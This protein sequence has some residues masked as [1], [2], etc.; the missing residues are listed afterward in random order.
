MNILK[1]LSRKF[2]TYIKTRNSQLL[3]YELSKKDY[4]ENDCGLTFCKI[5]QYFELVAFSD[6]QGHSLDMLLNQECRNR[7]E[8]GS[9]MIVALSK[10]VWVSYG[11]IA[12]EGEF[13]IAEID[14]LINI[15]ASSNNAVLFDF[16]T[17]EEYR[18]HGYYPELLK[19]ILSQPYYIVKSL[20]YCY[21]SNIS[22]VR[23][24][25]KAGG[26]LVARLNHYSDAAIFFK[27][28]GMSQDGSKLKWLGLLYN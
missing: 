25:E 16:A 3:F 22:S 26:I 24:I 19:Y 12:L 2:N 15:N 20:I 23:G 5:N 1:I 14:K 4:Y 10:G 21:D 11:W 17:R 9:Q 18:G 8:K 28:Y 6:Q 13:W 7:F 27:S